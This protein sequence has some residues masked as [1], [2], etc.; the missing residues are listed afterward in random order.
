MAANYTIAGMSEPFI[1][2]PQ[3][4]MATERDED[5]RPEEERPGRTEEGEAK[6]MS[7]SAP[8]AAQK[9]ALRRIYN[10][11]RAIGAPPADATSHLN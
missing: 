5:W 9:L 3:G 10:S 7:L 6:A 11:C 4:H 1:E 2:V 8:T